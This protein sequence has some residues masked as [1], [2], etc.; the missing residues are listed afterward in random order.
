MASVL[1]GVRKEKKS[2]NTQTQTPGKERTSLRQIYTVAGSLHL[3]CAHTW[4]RPKG[5]S[6]VLVVVSNNGLSVG[7]LEL[8]CWALKTSVVLNVIKLQ[9]RSSDLNRVRTVTPLQDHSGHPRSWRTFTAS[10]F[11]TIIANPGAV[12]PPYSLLGSTPVHILH[13]NDPRCLPL[14]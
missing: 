8:R 2:C 3:V 6:V 13:S 11:P 14:L 5:P 10:V 9:L 4:E 1:R 12:S 7:A